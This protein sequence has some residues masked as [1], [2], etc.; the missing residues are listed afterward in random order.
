M[1]EGSEPCG[2]GEEDCWMARHGKKRA[3]ARS[4]IPK[5][6]L[7]AIT[8]PQICHTGNPARAILTPLS[9]DNMIHDGVT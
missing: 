8:Q 3:I 2:G 4:L 5:V 6:V 1:A 9:G 7:A